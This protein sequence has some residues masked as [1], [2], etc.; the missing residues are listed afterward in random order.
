MAKRSR[1]LLYKFLQVSDELMDSRSKALAKVL[2]AGGRRIT[3]GDALH[4]ILRLERYVVREADDETT[5]IK[6]ELLKS[7]TFPADR[8]L[9]ALELAT[10]WP[11]GKAGMLLDALSDP[12]V[13]VLE[14]VEGGWRVRGLADRYAGFAVER[15]ASRGRATASRLAKKHGYRPQDDGSW[16]HPLTQDRLQDWQAVLNRFGGTSAAAEA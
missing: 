14:A 7:S 2:S 15:K 4:L 8:I 11:E 13:K 1:A 16:V 10:D 9:A 3:Q 12:T 5:D 6:A